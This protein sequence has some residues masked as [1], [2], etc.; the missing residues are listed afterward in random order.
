MLKPAILALVL[1]TLTSAAFAQMAPKEAE[2]KLQNKEA[3]ETVAATQPSGLTNAQ[4]YQM[5]LTIK[6]L[7]AEN[8]RLQATVA[9]LQQ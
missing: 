6:Q 9:T 4:V 3:R 5:E 1:L 8:D 7:D 2:A